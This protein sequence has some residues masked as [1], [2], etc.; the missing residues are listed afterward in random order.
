LKEALTR[1]LQAKIPDAH[2]LRLGNL[3]RPSAGAS[4]E[5]QLFEATWSTGA[6][7]GVLRAAPDGPGV[8]PEYDLGRQFRVLRAVHRYSDAPVPE[9]LWLESDPSI[10]G[11]PFFVMRQVSGRAPL[12]HPSYHGEGFY[13]DATP[14]TRRQIWSDS[15][16]ALARLHDTPIEELELDDLREPRLD[17]WTRYHERWMKDD[18]SESHPVLDAALGWL[19][20]HAEPAKRHC[21]CWGDA[22]LGN[23]LFD[24]ASDH[25]LTALLDWEMAYLGDPELD[26][27][28][29]Y[30]SDL[31]AHEGQN[32]PRLE[33]TP[34]REALIAEYQRRGGHE[35]HRFHYHEVFATFWRGTVLVK[36]LKDLRAKGSDVPETMLYEN[37]MI[38]HLEQ[39]LDC[40]I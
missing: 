35:V 6:L 10:L 3:L 13:R 20:A 15:I 21:L 31:R 28:S 16:D 14:E 17:Y 33:G 40:P 34:T 38:S 7:A 22:K 1:W 27:A 4:S 30:I 24:P 32:L 8:F 11:V 26:L 2:D 5:T 36:I 19:G 9:P 18:P 12:D 25:Q 23:A 29:L 39:L 37:F